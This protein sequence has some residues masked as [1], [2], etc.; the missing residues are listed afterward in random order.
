MN[1]FCLFDGYEVDATNIDDYQNWLRVENHDI[2]KCGE[3]ITPVHAPFYKPQ[4]R[5]YQSKIKR[6]AKCPQV[7]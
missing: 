5:V 1:E 3:Q 2:L 6:G 7:F 4:N